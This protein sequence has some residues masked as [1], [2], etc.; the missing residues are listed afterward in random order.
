MSLNLLIPCK[1]L[2]AGKSRLAPV[3]GE[4]ERRALCADLLRQTLACALALAPASAC[5]LVSS[6]AEAV[7]LAAAAGVGAI[8]DRGFG[9]N[10]ALA[11]ARAW[12]R[13]GD[14]AAALLV[15]PIDLPR[16]SAAALRRLMALPAEVVAAPDRHGIGTNALYLSPAAAGRFAFRFGSGSFAAHRDAAGSAGLRF[17][18]GAD[19]DLAFDLDEPEDLWAWRGLPEPDR[20]EPSATRRSRR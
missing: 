16:A 10:P 18:A 2:A 12:L 15:L 11:E 3:L 4:A 5:H 7:A 20:V 13:R 1:P 17:A 6:D 9:L 14:A 8:A 19:P